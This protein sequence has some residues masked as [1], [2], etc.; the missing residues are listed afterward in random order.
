[1][2]AL[3]KMLSL[4]TVMMFVMA[5]SHMWMNDMVLGVYGKEKY[6]GR[7]CKFVDFKFSMHTYY[8]VGRN[9]YPWI[10]GCPLFTEKR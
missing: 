9:G 3:R 10:H 2:V 1:M 6:Q 7:V 5:Y 8:I 4:F